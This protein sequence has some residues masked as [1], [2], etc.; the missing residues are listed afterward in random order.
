MER[1][2]NFEFEFSTL[3]KAMEYVGKNEEKA[4]VTRDHN[5]YYVV[6]CQSVDQYLSLGYDHV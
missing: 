2:I 1:E 6:D 5:M 4:I 3:E